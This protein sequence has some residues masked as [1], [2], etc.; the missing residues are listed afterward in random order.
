MP[1]G[2]RDGDG[3]AVLYDPAAPGRAETVAVSR[4][5][6]WK[7]YDMMGLV[8]VALLILVVVRTQG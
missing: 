2:T 5:P 1:P 4:K 8:A 7:H 6:L 3:V